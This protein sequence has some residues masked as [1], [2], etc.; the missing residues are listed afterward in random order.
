MHPPICTVASSYPAQVGA[1]KA[2][3]LKKKAGRSKKINQ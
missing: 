2:A 3:R 1:K